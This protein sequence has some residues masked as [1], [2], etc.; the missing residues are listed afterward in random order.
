VQGYTTAHHLQQG[1]AAKIY[2]A[3]GGYY[4]AGTAASK[5]GGGGGGSAGSCSPA[6]SYIYGSYGT[7]P[8]G[9]GRV[10]G[11]II[12]IGRFFKNN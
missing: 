3:P 6:P 8:Y 7:Y 5:T 9:S 12:A 10:I 11:P 1:G 4:I 2:P